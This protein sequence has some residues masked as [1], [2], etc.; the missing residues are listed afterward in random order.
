MSSTIVLFRSDLRLDDNPALAHAA[1]QSRPVIPL[2]VL[3]EDRS[4][5]ADLRT[6]TQSP[7]AA[8]KVWLDASLRALDRSLRELGSRLVISRGVQNTVVDELIDR[9]EIGEVVWNRRYEPAHIA[10]DG[11]L[12]QMLRDR[13][14]QARSFNGNLLTE[15]ARIENKQGQPYKVFTPFY[16]HCQTLDVDLP[17]NPPTRLA[18]PPEWPRSLDVD[19]LRLRPA[20]DWDS[21]IR[22]LWQPG[23]N[24]ARA[25]L[26]GF[27]EEPMPGYQERRDVPSEPGTSRLSPYLHFGEISPRRIVLEARHAAN[28]AT[29]FIRQLYW[30]EFAHHLLFHFPHTVDRPLNERF[31]DF[32]WRDDPNALGRWQRGQTGY[33]LVDA[34]MREL[35]H[36]GWMHNR[37]RM[38]VASFLTKHLL[39]DWR[40]GEQWFWD[41]LV[42]A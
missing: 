34:G 41:T 28:G 29:P 21:G 7:G 23:E 3:G 16:K 4:D 5:C 42:D 37:V 24:G 40:Y 36:T 9:F 12:K 27:V 26:E 20:I 32:P 17:A 11:A 25:L 30:R 15:P 14:I 1:R 35:W 38:I 19:A 18:A 39:I 22:E 31:E 8:S 10:E 33:P 2:F 6:L 13:G